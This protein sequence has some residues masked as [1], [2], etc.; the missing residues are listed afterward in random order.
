[1]EAH[2]HTRKP[3]VWRVIDING[4]RN[5]HGS[6]SGTPGGKNEPDERFTETRLSSRFSLKCRIK[7]N[8]LLCMEEQT[9]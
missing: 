6:G 3:Y 8:L 1:M 2:D 7:M 9:F 5:Q 4:K